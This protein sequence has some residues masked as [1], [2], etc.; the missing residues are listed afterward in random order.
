MRQP[1]ICFWAV[2]SHSQKGTASEMA[3]AFPEL[4][5][6]REFCQ[7]TGRR[8]RYGETEHQGVRNCEGHRSKFGV[9]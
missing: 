8:Y 3:G 1:F 4:M 6:K 9:G 7:L 2:F 5:V